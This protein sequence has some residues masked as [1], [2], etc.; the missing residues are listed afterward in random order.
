MIDRPA[1]QPGVSNQVHRSRYSV[2]S[3]PEPQQ[4]EQL[5]IGMAKFTAVQ[6][7]PGLNGTFEAFFVSLIGKIVATTV[8]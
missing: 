7:P 8:Q 6:G 5:A 1:H 2:K 4:H 3:R